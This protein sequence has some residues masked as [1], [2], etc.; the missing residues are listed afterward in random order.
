MEKGALVL[1]GGSLRGM[2]TAGVLDVL[3]ENGI[4]IEYV[5]GVS[6]GSMC[7]YN[8]ISRQPGRTR[9]I[10]ETFCSDRKFMGLR[11]LL[12]SGDVFNFDYLFGEISGTLCPADRETFSASPQ[13][14]EAVATDCLTG[15]EQYFRKGEMP[16]E[17]FELA[18]RAS[19]SMPT[20]S[21]TVEID[22]VPYLDGGCACP[23]AYHRAMELG[24]EK[25]AAVLTRPA[26]YRKKPQVGRGTTA[27]E[28][29]LYARKYPRLF[30]ALQEANRRYNAMYTEL[31]RMEREGR[32]FLLRPEGPVLVS[33]LERSTDK[34]EVL[35]Q[36]GRSVCTRR[37]EELKRYLGA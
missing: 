6:A 37:L 9:Q 17:T 8:Y 30:E 5:N 16:L 31:E 19:S 27:A 20:L 34:L 12:R 35:Y 28:R 2:F 21:R 7:G 22:G 29:R 23:I 36:Q 24:Y 14:F 13:I 32:I 10:D 15:R 25:V 3:M 26:G 4:W 18:C 1:E 33:R 11:N